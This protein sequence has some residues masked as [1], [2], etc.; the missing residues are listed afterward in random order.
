MGSRGVFALPMNPSIGCQSVSQST[1]TF[2]PSIPF[3]HSRAHRQSNQIIA[4]RPVDNSHKEM[5][6]PIPPFFTYTTQ[7]L[8]QKYCF[9]H[10]SENCK[11]KRAQIP[12]ATTATAFALYSWMILK[13]SALLSFTF[14]F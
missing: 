12:F 9:C 3:H 7:V 4:P 5:P 13:S 8:L 14:P 10:S 6:M 1:D 11:N 2:P